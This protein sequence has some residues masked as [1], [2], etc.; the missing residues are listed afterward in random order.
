MRRRGENSAANSNGRANTLNSSPARSPTTSGTLLPSPRAASNSSDASATPTA[1]EHVD[2][3]DAILDIESSSTLVA[4]EDRLTRLFENLFRNSVEHGGDIPTI[5]VGT[6]DSGGFY[7][8]DDGP[9]IPEKNREEIFDRGVTTED[10]GTGFG[11]AIVDVI[12]GAHDWSITVTDS[13]TGG[14][15]FEIET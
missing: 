9:G 12:V 4:N 3:G 11:L 7:V 10:D 5:R 13:E 1:W 6:L 14:A 2:T 15:R 8:E